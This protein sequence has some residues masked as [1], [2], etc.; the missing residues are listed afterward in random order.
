MRKK[1]LVT[2][3][4]SLKVQGHPISVPTSRKSMH[5]TGSALILLEVVKVF[6]HV[7]FSGIF[8]WTFPLCHRKRFQELIMSPGVPWILYVVYLY[9]IAHSFHSSPPLA[10]L[11]PWHVHKEHADK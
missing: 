8:S 11:V 10:V 6:F 4:F 7:L 2:K 1:H 9:R 5:G 3:A